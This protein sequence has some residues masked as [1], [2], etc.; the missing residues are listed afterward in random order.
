MLIYEYERDCTYAQVVT[1]QL[2]HCVSV[3]QTQNAAH[4]VMTVVIYHTSYINGLG[5]SYPPPYRSL[6]YNN[7]ILSSHKYKYNIEG[8]NCGTSYFINCKSIHFTKRQRNAHHF[9][10]CQTVQKRL[11]NLKW[12]HVLSNVKY[13]IRINVRW[14]TKAYSSILGVGY[15][16]I[17]II[18]T[19][20]DQL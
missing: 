11:C 18:S 10:R 12:R 14:E 1:A 4:V 3:F 2:Y 20:C 8:N 19:R 5:P 13:T 6:A 17:M 7:R 16:T 15:D 9:F